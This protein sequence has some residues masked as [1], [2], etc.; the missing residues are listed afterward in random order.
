MWVDLVPCDLVKLISYVWF[1]DFLLL[2]GKFGGIFMSL[3]SRDR[4][5]SSFAICIDSFLFLAIS[6]ARMLKDSDDGR[7]LVLDLRGNAF[8]HSQGSVLHQGV[9]CA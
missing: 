2:L 5:I 4:L 8:G 9:L 6:L 3:T 7:N 1:L